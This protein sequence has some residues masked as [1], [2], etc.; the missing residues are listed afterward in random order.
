M[1]ELHPRSHRIFNFPRV[2]LTL[3]TSAPQIKGMAIPCLDDCACF[4]I[5]MNVCMLSSTAIFALVINNI[6]MQY[7]ARY[8]I[9]LCCCLYS[10]TYFLACILYCYYH[11]I[12]L[13]YIFLS[14]RAKEHHGNLRTEPKYLVFLSQLLLLFNICPSCKAANALVETAQT[15]TMVAVHTYCGNPDC[16]QR[17][18]VAQSTKYGRHKDRCRKLSLKFRYSFGWS[19]S[20]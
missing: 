5:V 7:Q 15:G 6:Y 19:L 16:K 2:S 4:Y 20:K 8:Y 11:S 13:F 1:P 14:S 3:P 18:C 17:V 9:F 12:N 10:A